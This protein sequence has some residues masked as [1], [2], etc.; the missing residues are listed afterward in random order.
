[1]LLG[2]ADV[3]ARDPF[4]ATGVGL[5][6][7]RIHREAFAADEPRRHA[8][9]H[10]ALEDMAEHIAVAEAAV[11]VDRKR[12]M[13]G[14]SILETQPAEPA[15]GEVHLDLLAQPTL[16]ADRVAVAD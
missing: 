11:A 7:A 8:S 2:P 12:R 6:H 4:E 1:L 13:V 15:V 14:N 10:H 16:R 5:D 3:A 9:A